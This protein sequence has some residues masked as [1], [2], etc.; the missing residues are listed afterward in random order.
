MLTVALV[1]A[2]GAGKSSVIARLETE[3][4]FPMRRMYLGV[5]AASA[6]HPLPTTRALR[7]AAAA[8][9]RS[10]PSGGPPPLRSPGAGSS[11]DRRRPSARRGLRALART[12]NRI[13]EEAYQELISRWHQS[14]GRIVVYD[15]F[16]P[17]DYHAHDLAGHPGLSWDRRAHGR[18]LRWCFP[19]PDLVLVLDAEPEILHA[20][21]GEGTLAELA[22]RR[23]EYLAYASTVTNAEVIRVDRPL[24]DVMVAVID[25][26]DRAVERASAPIAP[27]TP[28]HRGH[29][30]SGTGVVDESDAVDEAGTVGE[31]SPDHG[32]STAGDPDATHEAGGA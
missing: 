3:L 30:A 14:C 21:K 5:S 31:A 28:I 18:F 4:P 9:G 16:Y 2:D 25:A 23:A 6:S 22:S 20:R 7:W 8:T 10:R 1:G 26:I 12:S 19:E 32:A 11:G 13:T 29:P 24:D 17:A 15:R 27:S